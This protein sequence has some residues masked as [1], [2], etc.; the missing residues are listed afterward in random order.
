VTRRLLVEVT[1]RVDSI[2]DLSSLG[3][4]SAAAVGEVVRVRVRIDDGIASCVPRGD[5][6][7]RRLAAG[8]G[9]WDNVGSD[10]SG[11]ARAVVRTTYPPSVARFRGVG[12]MTR[13]RDLIARFLAQPGARSVLGW[14]RKLRTALVDHDPSLPVDHLWLGPILFVAAGV[15]LLIGQWIG[16]P[17]FR[18]TGA[19][20]PAPPTTGAA[21]LRCRASGRITPPNASPHEIDERPTTLRA[22]ST[23]GTQVGVELPVGRL[24]VTIPRLLDGLGSIEAGDLVLVSRSV[25]ALKV[26]WYGTNLLL[27]FADR[28]T[29]DAAAALIG[30]G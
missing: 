15:L 29:R 10:P 8:I 1:G 26:D 12:Q 5:C 30:R 3:D 19:A 13:D 9:S 20:G 28:E 14:G 4:A 2:R 25:P 27:T 11:D 18:A 24:E 17:L 16:Y 7:A 21:V 23:A 22:D 6:A